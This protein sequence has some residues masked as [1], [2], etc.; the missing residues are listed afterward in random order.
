MTSELTPDEAYCPEGFV[1]TQ[2][3]ALVREELTA[4]RA[5][6]AAVRPVLDAALAYPDARSGFDA[7]NRLIHA[8]RAYRAAV[9]GSAEAPGEPEQKPARYLASVCE[10]CRHAYNHHASTGRCEYVIRRAPENA[11]YQGVPEIEMCECSAFVDQPAVSPG[12]GQ[13]AGD[14]TQPAADVIAAVDSAITDLT[15]QPQVGAAY[16]KAFIK[17]LAENG[18]VVRALA[19]AGAPEPD[20][21]ELLL[22]RR[23]GRM[24]GRATIGHSRL[25]LTTILEYLRAGDSI[26][27]V[28]AAYPS[29]TV[30]QARVVAA[31]R[32]ELDAP[33]DDEEAGAPA[34]PDDEPG[35]LIGRTDDYTQ[36]GETGASLRAAGWRTTAPDELLIRQLLHDRD[37]PAPNGRH[38]GTET[39]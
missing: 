3:Y 39:P 23:P 1:T 12:V 13:P 20:A 26:D 16:A 18:V 38:E 17:R 11:R 7:S 33:D 36:D 30:E 5:R 25:P 4:A 32:D 35:R 9:G 28:V 6:E 34:Q 15:G 14:T 8:V 19:E 10:T 31:L 24:S 22:V 21:D 27:L 29:L 37:C 2:A